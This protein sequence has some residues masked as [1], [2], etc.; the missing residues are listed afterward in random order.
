M[1][2]GDG[3]VQVNVYAARPRTFRPWMAPA[4]PGPLIARPD[5]SAAL[6][7]GVTRDDAGPTTLTTAIEGAGG[8]G[9]TTLAALL[10]QDPRV[11]ERFT[12]GLLWVTVG[13]R[14]HGARLAELIGGLCEML[15]GDGVKTADPQVAGGRL[16]ELLDARDA[17][18]M[19]VDDVWRPEQLAPFMIG[20]RACRR[21]VTT[22]NSGVAPRRGVSVFVDVMTDDQAIAAL[23]EGVGEVPRDLLG[24]LVAATGRWPLLLSLVN[25]AL[26]DQL[27]AGADVRQAVQWVLR[28]L[29]SGGPAMFDL[30]PGDEDDRSHAIAATVDASL[31]L[32]TPHERSCYFDLA[33]IPEDS[34]LPSE[35]LFR[36]WRTTG[37][38]SATE[39]EKL[40]ARLVRLRLVQPGWRDGAPAVRLHDIIGSFLRHRLTGEETE[41]RHEQ[42]VRTAAELLPASREPGTRWW[43]MPRDV[44]YL[45][46]HLPYH[47]ARSGRAEERNSLVCDLRWV[48]AKATKLGSSVPVEA[49]LADVPTGVARTL[50][51]ALGSM[52]DLLTP[53]DPPEALDATLHCYL[54]GVPELRS[55]AADYRSHLA[56][57]LLVPAWPPPDQAALGVLRTLTRHTYGVGT[58]HT[59][60]ISHCAFSPDGTL[61]ATASHDRSV[62]L[63]NVTTVSPV[64]VL[65]GHTE[66]VSACA[67]SPDGTLLATTSHDRSVRLWDVATG[68]ER[69]VLAGHSEAVTSCAFSPDGTLLA[70]TSHDRSIRLWDPTTA[71][72]VSVLT[73]HAGA[74][75]ACAFSPDGSLLATTGYDR[76]ARLW[77]VA[78]GTERSVLAGHSE[79]VTGCA[80]SPDGTL[81][82]TAGHDRSVRLW[83]VTTVSPVSVLTGHT[84]AVSACAFSPDGSLLA[85]TGY[86]QTAR[87]WDVATGTERSVLAGHS[88][89]VT[90]CAFSPDGTLLATAGHDWRVLLW[91]TE[92]ET[93]QVQHVV[94][95][96]YACA[97]SPDGTLVA[98]AGHD[99]TVRIWDVVSGDLRQMFEGHNDLV[100]SCAFSPDGTLVVSGS[101][102]HTVQVWET[103]TGTLRTVLTGHTDLVTSCAF[104]PDGT[105]IA[106]AGHDDTVRIWR[107]A[108]GEPV[109]VLTGHTG[110]ISACAFSPDGTLIASASHDHTVRVWESG[111]GATRAV[112]ASHT[113]LVSSCAFS[114]D[115]TLIASAGHDRTTK[116]WDAASGAL[117]QTLGGHASGVT[118][119]AFAPDG[120]LATTDIGENRLWLWR[121]GGDT[122]WCGL[123]VFSPLL[124]LAWHPTQPLL[125]AVGEAGVYLLRCLPDGAQEAEV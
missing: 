11:A 59:Y 51:R 68:T 25:A 62:R 58:G 91:Q 70:T 124:Q 48:A 92:A 96:E 5:L 87:L 45:W 17:T 6:F 73:G 108:G 113:D 66:A 30:D 112:L 19:V 61:L 82:A 86:D 4:L 74:V 106:S 21:L 20:G 12:G 84:E 76:T 103:A 125:C 60:G 52:T 95:W 29:R 77:D 40:R 78:T 23:T 10:C 100:S 116:V 118:S 75:S 54:S 50:R 93:R 115:G 83:N 99:R 24:R 80:F 39:A 63:W 47:L 9:K 15:S 64:S 26:L 41:A 102:D 49:D 72:P 35:I 71:E 67:F 81:L 55:P 56:A 36:L 42:M 123:R 14:R 122:P 121:P 57:P 43:S 38:L 16:G 98:S 85:T 53:S 2:I 34:N 13:E 120:T 109:R 65:T 88:E 1:Q 94:K 79:A 97:F 22:R 46:H 44:T 101:H 31:A 7:D 33:I 27:A 32:L 90:S 28:Q 37:G 89:A 105:L 69:S 111:T 104:S 107:T 110:A 119:C 3:G 114:P 117:R 8:F 18:L